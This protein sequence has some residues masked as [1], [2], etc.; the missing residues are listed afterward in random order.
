MPFSIS[1]TKGSHIPR[2]HM[3]HATC[4]ESRIPRS[5]GESVT[6]TC[7]HDILCSGS[8]CISACSLSLEACSSSQVTWLNLVLICSLAKAFSLSLF[9]TNYI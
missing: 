3:S 4:G 9:S 2:S 1:W 8:P 7:G 6:V 5:C